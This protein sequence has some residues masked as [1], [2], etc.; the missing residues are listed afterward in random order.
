MHYLGLPRKLSWSLDRY[1]PCIIADNAM[2]HNERTPDASIIRELD[3][4]LQ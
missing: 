4:P 2:P 1:T 3:G